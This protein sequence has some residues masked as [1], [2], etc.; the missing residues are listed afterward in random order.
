MVYHPFAIEIYTRMQNALNI[1]Q[2]RSLKEEYQPA[3]SWP[4]VLVYEIL[5]CYTTV[6]GTKKEKITIAAS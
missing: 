5:K 4:G 3:P 6:Y 2:N 1:S